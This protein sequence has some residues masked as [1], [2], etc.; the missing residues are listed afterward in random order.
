MLKTLRVLSDEERWVFECGTGKRASIQPLELDPEKRLEVWETPAPS[1]AERKEPEQS[2]PSLWGCQ[3]YQES[4]GAARHPAKR[5]TW[6]CLYPSTFLW[7]GT[8]SSKPTGIFIQGLVYSWFLYVLEK[9]KWHENS[10][11]LEMY[12]QILTMLPGQSAEIPEFL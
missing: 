6:Q 10:L 7:F 9:E 5:R 12:I 11:T 1:C 8:L 4:A 2:C 3:G